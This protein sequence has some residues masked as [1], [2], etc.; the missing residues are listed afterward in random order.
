MV[1]S[2]YVIAHVLLH[3]GPFAIVDQMPDSV[4]IGYLVLASQK[5]SVLMIVPLNVRVYLYTAA[6]HVLVSLFPMDVVLEHSLHWPIL[7]YYC[8]VRRW[9]LK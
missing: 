8:F 2:F 3:G 7:L 9:K 5:V 4:L 1:F 6:G